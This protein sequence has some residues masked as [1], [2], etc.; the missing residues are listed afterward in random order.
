M[1]F[2]EF[3]K[4]YEGY[5]SRTRR[6]LEINNT[7]VILYLDKEFQKEI[8]INPEFRYFLIKIKF[9]TSRVYTNNPNKSDHWKAEIDK[10]LKV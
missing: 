7:E 2:K 3:N 5:L 9:G 10:I 1:D 6:G 4:K 8:Q